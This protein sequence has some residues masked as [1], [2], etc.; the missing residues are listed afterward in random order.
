[1][2]QTKPVPRALRHLLHVEREQAALEPD[3]GDVDHRG[4]GGLEHGDVVLLLGPER[5][6]RGDRARGG[7]GA[8]LGMAGQGEQG[9]RKEEREEEEGSHGAVGIE[10]ERGGL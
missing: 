6:A 2:S 9:G 5:A 1:M 7:L 10:R 3:R 8:R 4:R